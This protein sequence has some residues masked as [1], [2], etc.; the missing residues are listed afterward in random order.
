MHLLDVGI[1]F[2]LVKFLLEPS[3]DIFPLPFYYIEETIENQNVLRTH[4]LLVQSDSMSGGILSG[5]AE[6]SWL[7]YKEYVPSCLR[8][9]NGFQIVILDR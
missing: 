8:P 7:D 5:V 3:M 6:K 9:S 4:V 2:S 1:L